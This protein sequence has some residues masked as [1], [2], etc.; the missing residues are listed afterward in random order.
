MLG[1]MPLAAL[2]ALLTFPGL[3]SSQDDVANDTFRM[4]TRNGNWITVQWRAPNIVRV[5][6]SDRLGFANRP[7]YVVVPQRGYTK[8]KR[9]FR[10]GYV[11]LKSPE[12]IVNVGIPEGNVS[13]YDPAGK[14]ITAETP[15]GR[16]FEASVEQGETV[17]RVGQRWASQ[18]DESLYGL[19]QNQLGL[20][21]IKGFDQDLW[22]HN[23]S[24]VV[25]FLASSKGYGILWDNLSYTRF[26][27]LRPW[28][29]IP[30]A[31]FRTTV[32]KAG[33]LTFST[34]N[35]FGE[36]TRKEDAKEVDIRPRQRGAPRPPDIAQR[37][38]TNS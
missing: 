18:P 7:S 37:T 17:H 26:G 36:S 23:T 30:A 27:D 9:V 12:L 11:S 25:P 28:R 6:E 15:G 19:G 16:T 34:R 22:Q 21:D 1:P 13:F 5:C 4:A 14:R 38:S 10:D 2:L 3:V 8:F 35:R 20:V 24:I 32:G 33:A 31:D 29:P